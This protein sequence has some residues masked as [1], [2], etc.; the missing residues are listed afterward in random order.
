MEHWQLIATSLIVIA[1]GLYLLRRIVGVWRGQSAGCGSGTDACGQCPSAATPNQP[2]VIALDVEF[3]G[4]N[5]DKT[6]AI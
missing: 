3:A 6:P 4:R 2:D 1:A 5:K